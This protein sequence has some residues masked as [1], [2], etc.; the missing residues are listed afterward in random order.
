M[1]Y[2]AGKKAERIPNQ[3]HKSGENR[4]PANRRDFQHPTRGQSPQRPP[5]KSVGPINSGIKHLRRQKHRAAKYYRSQKQHGFAGLFQFGQLEQQ[6]AERV[7]ANHRQKYRGHFRHASH[8]LPIGRDKRKYSQTDQDR[9]DRGHHA[10]GFFLRFFLDLFAGGGAQ[11]NIFNLVQTQ[12]LSQE[13]LV[14]FFFAF[15]FF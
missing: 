4:Q 6:P 3:A 10:D 8:F 15:P 12:T 13:I 9:A 11:K 1:V 2:I 5:Q 7:H 14:N